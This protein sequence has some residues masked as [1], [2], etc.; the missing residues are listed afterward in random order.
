MREI[1]PPLSSAK[2]VATKPGYRQFA[3]APVLS[4]RHNQARR[5]QRAKVMG[6]RDG[7]RCA[8]ETETPV[9]PK[10]VGAKPIK[11]NALDEEKV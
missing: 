7:C 8:V 5:C 10:L 9:T 3:V 1:K 2:R 11:A 4:R 6:P